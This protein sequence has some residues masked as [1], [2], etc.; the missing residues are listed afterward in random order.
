MLRTFLVIVS[1]LAPT[2][3]YSDLASDSFIYSRLFPF[4]FTASAIALALWVVVLFHKM[5]I[6]QVSDSNND[7]WDL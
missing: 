6:D 3:F 4:L 1:V 7:F 5:G 2:C